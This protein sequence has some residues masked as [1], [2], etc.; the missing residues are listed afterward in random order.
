MAK[1]KVFFHENNTF[2]QTPYN[3][4]IFVLNLKSNNCKN[5]KF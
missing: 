3:E 1:T 4:Y 2:T 5:L